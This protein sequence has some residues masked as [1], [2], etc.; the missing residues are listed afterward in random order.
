MAAQRGI[1]L[2]RILAK[3]VRSL[4][5]ARGMNQEELA[6]AAYL[7]QSQVSK[8]EAGRLNV[9]LDILQRL[10]SALGARPA[11]LLDDSRRG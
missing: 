5:K 3:N 6:D 8:I 11:E 7:T 2:R 10:G 4:R 9:R 1:Y